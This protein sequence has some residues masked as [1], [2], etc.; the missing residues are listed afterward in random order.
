MNAQLT[1]LIS[2]LLSLFLLMGV[3]LLSVKMNVLPLSATNVLSTIIMSITLPASVIC[4][5]TRADRSLLIDG[6]VIVFVG[7]LVYVAYVVFSVPLARMLHIPSAD[8]GAWRICCAFPNNGFMGFPII[9]AVLGETAFALAVVMSISFNLTFFTLGA[10]Q[11]MSR[12]PKNAGI[13]KISWRS[14]LISSVNISTIIG[15]VLVLSGIR[16]PEIIQM[17]MDYLNELTT[18]LSMLMIG[19]RLSSSSVREVIRDREAVSA[20]IIRLVIFPVLTWL[21]LNLFSFESALLV[22]VVIMTVAMPSAAL[23]CILTER[24]DGNVDLSVKIVFLC[25]LLCIFTIPLISML[26]I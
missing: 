23:C 11:L 22:P 2:S 25:D 19:M 5:L 14:V 6:A 13:P 4:S 7:L 15:L 12:Q 17:P 9:L 26:I 3:G 20:A 1:M 16:I 8:R 18:P 10:C 21:I 24:Y